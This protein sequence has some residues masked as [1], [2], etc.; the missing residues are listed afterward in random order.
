MLVIVDDNT[1]RLSLR[2]NL[3]FVA[4]DQKHPHG[5]THRCKGGIEAKM[6]VEGIEVSWTP[7]GD[8]ELGCNRV[9]SCPS[10]VL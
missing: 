8:K 5:D 9:A 2:G 6:D 1:V 7:F 10:H 4:A 3:S